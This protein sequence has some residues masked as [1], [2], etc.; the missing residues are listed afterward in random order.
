MAHDVKITISMTKPV[1]SVG[2]GCP[3][4][5]VTEA[6]K[7]LDY[8]KV[9]SLEALVT[10]GSMVSEIEY[11]VAQLM[12]MQ[13]HAPKE[14]AV[15]VTD[16]TAV[17]WLSEQSNVAKDWRQLIVIGAEASEIA[18]I[19]ATIE[20]Q[21][22]YPKMYYAN[23]SYDDTT[24]LSVE[25]I[26]RTVICYYTP[27]ED[28]LVPVAALVG[29]VAGCEIGSYTL[30]NMT[31]KGIEGLDLSETEIKAIHDKGGI[32]FVTSAGD[33]VASEGI[34]A[35]NSYVDNVDNNDWIQQQLEYKLQK[36]LNNNLK[37]PYTD[38][39]ISMLKTAALSVM[40]EAQNK[41]IV[42]SYTVNFAL[43]A[44]TTAEDRAARRYIGGNVTYEMAGAI[45]TVDIKC[46][47]SF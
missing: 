23:L 21:T 14:I 26:E 32:T 5:L 44:D 9:S 39:G 11:K 47:G 22:T 17:E 4:I 42:D 13:E 45:H 35:G 8:T 28:V 15:C 31:V 38:K 19:M 37:V 3:L 20:A 16:K 46:E 34:T 36:V 43:R 30:N 7:A 33:V 6:E 40:K 25:G 18:D 29:E 1:G 12:F 10:A 24:K 41:T 27:T 2:F